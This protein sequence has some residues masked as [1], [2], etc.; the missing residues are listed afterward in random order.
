MVNTAAE[1]FKVVG[2]SASKVAELVSEV[3]EAS[4]EQTQGIGQ[5]TQAMNQMDK[6]TQS[7]A[8]TAEESAGAAGQ[9]SLQ[10]GNLLEAVNEM[11]ALAHGS[12]GHVSGRSPR[13][14]AASAASGAPRRTA[15]SKSLPMSDDGFD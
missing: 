13:R 10:A 7:N 4:K 14:L 9:L 12:G 1:A 8:T 2:E 6:V 15:S 3:A 11:E 5:I